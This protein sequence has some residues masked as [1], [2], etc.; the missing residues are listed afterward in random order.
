MSLLFALCTTPALAWAVL[1]NQDGAELRWV[2]MP[3]AFAVNAGNGQGL[4]AGEVTLA[5]NAAHKAWEGVETAAI[6]FEDQGHTTVSTVDYDQ[7]NAVFF[8][9]NWNLDPELMA[10]T[11]N[12]SYSDGTVVGFDIRINDRDHGWAT[13]GRSDAD[14]L[15]NMLTHELGHCLGLDHTTADE[16]ATMYSAAIS[17]EVVKRVPKADDQ[18]GTRYLYGDGSP[19]DVNESSTA[20][21]SSAGSSPATWAGFSL[22]GLMVG[23]RRAD[24]RTD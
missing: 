21:C 16:E 18:A 1:E 5:V 14:D 23:R 15:Q 4:S 3:I 12:W 11:A 22:I 24:P 20:A 19:V 2:E 8:D 9:A 10:I 6:D 7:V 13:D 17:G